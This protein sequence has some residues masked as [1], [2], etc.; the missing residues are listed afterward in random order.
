MDALPTYVVCDPCCMLVAPLLVRTVLLSMD[1]GTSHRWVQ[2]IASC[3][4]VLLW[5]GLEDVG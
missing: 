1:E 3:T 4:F 2:R 5:Q